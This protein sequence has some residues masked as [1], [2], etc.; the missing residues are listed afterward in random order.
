MW[1][2]VLAKL[3]LVGCDAAMILQWQRNPAETGKVCVFAGRAGTL[4]CASRGTGES[5]ELPSW[6]VGE[7]QVQ[8]ACVDQCPEVREG[9]PRPRA[10][11]QKEA[12]GLGSVVHTA[13]ASEVRART[14]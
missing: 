8:A 12:T 5:L 1:K 3:R 11:E 13:V 2:T 4:F 7:G 14:P 10:S 6:G 9:L